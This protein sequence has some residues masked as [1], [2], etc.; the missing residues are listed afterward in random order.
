MG[1]PNSSRYAPTGYAGASVDNAWEQENLEARKMPE[2]AA[3]KRPTRP[4]YAL[5]G[6]GFAYL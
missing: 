6:S 4:L 2:N 3:A 5:L 1:L